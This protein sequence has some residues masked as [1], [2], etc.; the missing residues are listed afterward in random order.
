MAASF[1]E[2]HNRLRSIDRKASSLSEGYV[3]KVRK[4]GLIELQPEKKPLRKRIPLRYVVGFFGGAIAY[5]A[6]LLTKIGEVSYSA[7]LD[8]L[9]N[10]T[11][12]DKV[13]ATLMKID[14][15]TRMVTDFVAPYVG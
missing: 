11:T 3:P 13:G 8:V 9:L 15:V 14:P 5:K 2:F 6:Y 4:D 1:K 7:K 10:G 12:M